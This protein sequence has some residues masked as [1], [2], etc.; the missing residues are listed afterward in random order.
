[1]RRVVAR[2]AATAIDAMSWQTIGGGI[3]P[4][5][6]ECE[7]H[8]PLG[9]VGRR[10]T[11]RVAR[12]LRA[13]G[14]AAQAPLGSLTTITVSDRSIRVLVTRG[15]HVLQWTSADLPRGVVKGGV[16]TDQARFSR[17]V[18][19]VVR[20]LHEGSTTERRRTVMVVTGRNMVQGRFVVL[21]SDDTPLDTAV[22]A[23]AAERMAINPREIE[24]DW[25]AEALEPLEP[26]EGETPPMAG[27]ADED[28]PTGEALEVYALGLFGNVVKAGLDPLVK[29]GMVP[30]DSAPK[31][32]ALAAT[33]N[34]RSAV[35]LDVEPDSVSVV[36]VRDGMPEVVRDLRLDEGLSSAAWAEAVGSHIGRC[37]G[38]HDSLY[39]ESPL[40]PT[41][42]LFVSGIPV[43][44]GQVDA[45]V[46]GTPY[47]RRDLPRIVHAPQE[48]PYEEFAANVGVAVAAGKRPWQRSTAPVVDRP[49][50]HFLPDAY[51]PRALPVK[52]VLVGAAA[53]SLILGLG[54]AWDMV[55]SQRDDLDATRRTLAVVDG[56]L[57]Q[58]ALELRSA[59]RIRTSL[60]AVREQA[61]T[62]LAVSEVIKDRD[63]GF[64]SVLDTVASVRPAG[65]ALHEVDDDGALVTI[66]VSAANYDQLLD[67]ARTLA[68]Q[69]MALDL[70]ITSMGGGSGAAEPEAQGPSMTLELTRRLVPSA[71]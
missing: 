13:A 38:Y 30:A 54:T 49:R 19:S 34:E 70:R 18:A 66:R 29:L 53:A 63:R 44:P 20:S 58:R 21:E 15:N 50:L 64:A 56:R 39:P 67:Y 12:K 14:R 27:A 11:A 65:I 59:T 61:E 22:L 60:D 62:V 25:H 35:I 68:A 4:L 26:D 9:P 40:E 71:R 52:P 32:L 36:V 3:P 69:P 57:D 46:A 45:A 42:P 28:D 48:F 37:A 5:P 17:A 8:G 10:A 1:M 41:A 47:S 6:P 51:Q 43:D 33:A 7:D 2:A 16:V 55:G 24:L 31:A 23:L